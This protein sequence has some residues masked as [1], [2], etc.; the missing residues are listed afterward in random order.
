M[1][2]TIR[3]ISPVCS[4][5]GGGGGGGGET[6]VFPKAFEVTV[7]V[8]AG[9][10]AGQTITIP[11]DPDMLLAPS[12]QKNIQVWRE[13]FDLLQSSEFSVSGTTVTILVP[14]PATINSGSTNVSYT[15]RGWTTNY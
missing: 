6:P 8:A 12:G 4:G 14:T 7:S 9:T 15:V 10:P 3:F 5:S 2:S 11:Y 1:R 13:G